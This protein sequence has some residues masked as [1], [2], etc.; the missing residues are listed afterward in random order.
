MLVKWGEPNV[1]FLLKVLGILL[2]LVVGLAIL[3]LLFA[4]PR[5]GIRIYSTEERLNVWLRYGWL[6]IQ[7]F[8]L[9][10]RLQRGKQRK[11]KAKSAD[12]PAKKKT[13]Y[14]LSSFDLGEAV[15]LL[16]EVL[17]ELR[18][19]LH[20]ETVRMQV[21]LGTGNA[22]ATGI[23]LGACAAITGM[24]TPFL[25]KNFNISD[26]H[27]DIDGDFHAA[28]PRWEITLAF[29]VR[30]IRLLMALIWR[31]RRIAKL[32]HSMLKTEAKENE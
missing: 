31:W 10:A 3:L 4:I 29:S 20:L 28:R 26:Y 6:R 25:V 32:Y 17:E 8:P 27:V 18:N 19:V 5:A 13:S 22:A 21:M 12:I 16:L 9:P 11:D 14:D 7:I 1:M 24:L 2:A 23:L 30:P 15:Y